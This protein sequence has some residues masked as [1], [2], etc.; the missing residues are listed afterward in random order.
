MSRREAG[1]RRHGDA[2]VR[3]KARAERKQVQSACEAGASRRERHT[4]DR[5]SGRKQVT[6]RWKEDRVG[7]ARLNALR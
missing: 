2:G 4:Q 6:G 5:A 3:R 7:R 1:A